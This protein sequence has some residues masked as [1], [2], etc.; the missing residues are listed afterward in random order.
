[1]LSAAKIITRAAR[2]VG[3]V[4]PFDGAPNSYVTTVL[5]DTLCDVLGQWSYDKTKNYLWYYKTVDT[6]AMTFGQN[7]TWVSMGTADPTVT[8][9]TLYA[10][11]ATQDANGTYYQVIT[12]DG[13]NTYTEYTTKG[14]GT[15]Y[16]LTATPNVTGTYYKTTTGYKQTPAGTVGDIIDNP[17]AIYQVTTH[18]GPATTNIAMKET[19]V[20]YEQHP[21]KWIPGVPTVWAWDEQRPVSNLYLYPVPLTSGMTLTIEGIA[22]LPVPAN[23]QSTIDLPDYYE[24]PLVYEIAALATSVWPDASRQLDSQVAYGVKHWCSQLSGI[25]SRMR[26]PKV[27]TQYPTTGQHHAG[28]ANRWLRLQ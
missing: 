24:M 10:V 21:M 18:I 14:V 11:T 5:F 22:A 17:I 28:I 16:T 23:A 8:S 4:S 15:K 6:S 7:K 19:M 25:I 20:E 9:S 26:R 2:L 12:S 13:E 27:R 1:M 3:A